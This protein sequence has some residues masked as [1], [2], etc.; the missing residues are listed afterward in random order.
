M[1]ARI[2]W[3]EAKHPRKKGKFASKGSTNRW[4][5]VQSGSMYRIK[6]PGGL[7]VGTVG[8][9][10][11]QHPS[12]NIAEEVM[13]LSRRGSKRKLANVSFSGTK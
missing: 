11:W 3:D 8:G 4:T 12:R 5:L 6:K 10:T 7:F 9:Q 2:P 1:F 13:R